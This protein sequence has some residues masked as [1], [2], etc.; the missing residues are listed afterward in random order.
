MSAGVTLS[1]RQR[2]ECDRV[3]GAWLIL[4]WP[5]DRLGAA[6]A[7]ADGAERPAT[8]SE[9]ATAT[10]MLGDL[11]SLDLVH[12]R[13]EVWGRGF[14]R[15]PGQAVAATPV[16]PVRTWLAALVIGRRWVHAKGLRAARAAECWVDQR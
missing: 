15:R 12:I 8:A 13:S 6:P 2:K 11:G 16:R 9:H 5:A 1:N 7:M 10:A 14:G 3:G 4:A